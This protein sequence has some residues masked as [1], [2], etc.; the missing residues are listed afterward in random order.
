MSKHSSTLTLALALALTLGVPALAAP[1]AF[2]DREPPRTTPASGDSTTRDPL[3]RSPT[4]EAE[5][6]RVARDTEVGRRLISEFPGVSTSAAREEAGADWEVRFFFEGQVE[7]LV[8]VEAIGARVREQWT[9]DQVAW[10]MARGYPGAFGRTLN[11][12]WVW[13]PLCAIFVLGLFDWRRP[14]RVAHLDLLFLTAGL[15]LSH[16]F[17]N[18]GEIGLSVPLVYPVL[19]WLFGRMAWLGFNRG[20]RNA[21]GG[22]NPWL[23]PGVLAVA[24]LF[25]VGV[26]IAF[27]VADSNVI[28]VGY[29]GVIGGDLISS[30]QTLYGNFPESIANGDTYGPVSYFAYVPFELLFPWQGSWDDLPAAHAASVFFDLATMA[31]LFLLARRLFPAQRGQHSKGNAVGAALVFAWAACPYTAFALESNTNDSLVALAVVAILLAATSPSLRGVMVALASATKLAPLALIPMFANGPS[32][33]EDTRSAARGRGLPDPR[34]LAGYTAGLG[35][36]LAVVF[37]HA[38]ISPGP[39][40]V[41]ERTIGNQIGRESPFSIWGQVAGLA[42]LQVLVAVA[43]AAFAVWSAFRPRLRDPVVL[44]ALAAAVL[45]GVQLTFS[46]WFYLYLPWFLGAVFIALLARDRLDDE[47]VR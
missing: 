28:D 15:G 2:A 45:I 34:E 24:A 4:T 38:F 13:I 18:R 1:Q 31:A 5:A 6:I 36:G 7:G 32:D 26:R 3:D 16:Y 43:V 19:L 9:G 10:T 22:L 46:H 35:L 39:V 27:N 12:P 41:F 8:L 14:A 11:A 37:A 21:S 29:A 47:A 17:F 40:E 42:P 25:L 30:G 33:R 23:P 20:G 44:A